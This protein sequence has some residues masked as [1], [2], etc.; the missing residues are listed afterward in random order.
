MPTSPELRRQLLVLLNTGNAHMSFDEAV[1]GFP[2]DR[3]NDRAPNVPY[4]PWQLLEH[5]RIDQRDILNYIQDD[6]YD[7]L[8]FP[9]DLWPRRDLKAG[10]EEW[11]ETIRRF[12][13]DRHSLE[14]IVADESQDLESTV[15][16]NDQHTILREIITTASH[17]HY[18]IGEFA[19]LR[20]VMDTWGTGRTG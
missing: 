18:H 2:L 17:T 20:Q 19:I 16:T 3:I 10:E 11:N 6:P 5:I 9:D 13:E 8:R 12:K 15:P 4:T 1:S 14:A 7:E